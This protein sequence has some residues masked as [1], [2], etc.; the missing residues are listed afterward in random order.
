VLQNTAQVGGTV[1]FSWI[2]LQG[3]QYQI[4]SSTN[5]AQTN[6]VLLGGPIIAT[7]PAMVVSAAVGTNCQL[8]YRV[9]LLP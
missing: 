2:A 9:V 8:F 1:T 5:L 7:N 3:S 4:Q 6:W